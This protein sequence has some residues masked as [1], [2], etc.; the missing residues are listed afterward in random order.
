[1]TIKTVSVNQKANDVLNELTA[2][3]LESICELF[4]HDINI[5]DT[6]WQTVFDLK[7]IAMEKCEELGLQLE[8]ED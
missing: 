5:N 2:R 8:F 3:Y 4:G 1:M 6:D 7:E